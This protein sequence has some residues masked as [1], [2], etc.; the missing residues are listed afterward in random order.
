[1]YFIH[2]ED[3]SVQYSIDKIVLKGALSARNERSIW[4]PCFDFIEFFRRASLFKIK[5]Y[6][7]SVVFGQFAEFIVLEENRPDGG[8]VVFRFGFNELECVNWR[9]FQLVFNP[10]KLHLH[11][12]VSR[13]LD[14]FRLRSKEFYCDETDIAIDFPADIKDFS[15]IKDRRKKTTIDGGG[16]DLTYYLSTHRKNGFCKLY[17]KQLE[18]KLDYPLTRFEMTL[19]ADGNHRLSVF[20]FDKLFPQLIVPGDLQQAF[21][22]PLTASLQ[23]IYDACVQFPDLRDK[24]SRL[25][26]TTASK[27]RSRLRDTEGYF[28]PNLDIVADLLAVMDIY[29]HRCFDREEFD[30]FA[31]FP[32]DFL[33]GAARKG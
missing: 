27:V 20:D 7:C 29:L 12:D 13:F 30:L 26:P 24:L 6:P 23:W 17:N 4:Q 28:C 8:T 32:R 5:T 15:L 10:N 11:F 9:R 3:S 16:S 19:R 1:M 25:S 31:A 21:A 18:S 33:Q 14:Y 22:D 2:F